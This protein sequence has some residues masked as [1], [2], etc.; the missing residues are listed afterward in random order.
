MAFAAPASAKTPLH[1]IFDTDMGNDVDAYLALAMLHAL[2]SRGEGETPRR[3]REQR[4][5]PGPLNM[6]AVPVNESNGRPT[7]PARYRARWQRH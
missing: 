1:V 6:F 4:Q 3:H 7:I 2:A 5:S